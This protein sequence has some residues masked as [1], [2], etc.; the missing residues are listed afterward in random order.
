VLIDAFL[1]LV[2]K[3]CCGFA[4]EVDA[5]EAE[6]GTEEVDGFG[7]LAEEAEVED[8]LEAEDVDPEGFDACA[9]ATSA[10]VAD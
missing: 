6:F 5:E 7:G 8:A 10:S 4:A 3:T 9:A 1:G 2:L